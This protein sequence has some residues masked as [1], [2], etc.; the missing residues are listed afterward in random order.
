MIYLDNAATTFKKP[1][2]VVH[3]VKKCIKKY[4]AN[5]GRSGHKLSNL[6]SELLYDTRV[7]VS[8]LFNYNKPENVV[9]T[10]NATY[11]LNMAI[12][13]LIRK[14]GH[15]IISDREHNSVFRPLRMLSDKLGV[16][17]S[18]YNSRADNVYRE[19]E[20]LIRDDTYAIISTLQ[21]NVTGEVIP[22]FLLSELKKKYSLTLILDASQAAG[23]IPIDLNINEFDAFVA[24]G[25]K[26]L[27]GIMGVGFVIFNK[28]PDVSFIEGGSGSESRNE[29]MPGE[30]PERMEGG[31]VPLPAIASLGAGIDFVSRTR[32]GCIE[33]RLCYLTERLCEMLSDIKGIT[34]YGRENGIISFNISNMLAED[35]AR[36]LSERKI[37]VRAGLHCAPI[38]HRSLGTYESGSVRASLSYFNTERDISR[39]AYELIKLTRMN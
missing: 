19:I 39:L 3:A 9:F 15:V 31:T 25:H 34:I 32:V 7:K 11:G 10:M 1:D 14:K 5:P 37:C 30:L 33:N 27:F 36:R 6:A 38:A 16:E 2:S 8:A 28:I 35:V 26:A 29:Y 13:T 18:I 21:S 4:S 17:Y 24:P 22:I 23:H 12:K 20:G